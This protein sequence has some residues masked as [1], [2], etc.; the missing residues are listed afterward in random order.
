MTP[1]AASA[2]ELL[3]HT[4]AT[5]AYRGGKTLRDAPDSFAHFRS[6]ET[7]RTPAQILAHLGDLFDWALAMAKGQPAWHDSKPLP[8]H[9]EIQRFFAS[10]QKFDDYLASDAS[11]HASPEK[12]FQGPVADALNHIG[13]LAMLRRMAGSRIKGENYFQADISAGRVGPHQPK[14]N[15]EFD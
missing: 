10:L 1:P 7:T 12:L 15:L 8:W 2:R 14:P 11:L 4:L 3:R 13:Q 6:A 5:T 9:D